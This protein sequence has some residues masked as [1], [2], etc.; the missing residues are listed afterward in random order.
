MSILSVALSLILK[1]VTP[2]MLTNY[3][4]F[5]TSSLFDEVHA[6]STKLVQIP[7]QNNAY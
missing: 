5:I 4:E 1:K 6:L 3:E 7:T 2:A